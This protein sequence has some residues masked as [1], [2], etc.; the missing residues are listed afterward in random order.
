M[1]LYGVQEPQ[2]VLIAASFTHADLAHMIGVTR[3]WV[4]TALRRYAA[5]GIVHSH[6]PNIVIDD[7]DA[8]REIRDGKQPKSASNEVD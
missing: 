4:T 3:Q 8:L 5:L 1:D 6:G 7:A 2:G